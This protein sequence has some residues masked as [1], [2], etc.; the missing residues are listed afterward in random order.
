[1]ISSIFGWL[2]H[3]AS[4]FELGQDDAK[5]VAK[6]RLSILLIQDRIQLPPAKMEALKQDLLNVLS[7]YVEIDNNNVEVNI[8]QVPESRRIAIKSQVAVR[9]ILSQSEQ[10]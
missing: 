7:K 1:M 10:N 8:E 3:K 9:R 2:K 4:N 6:K 5:S